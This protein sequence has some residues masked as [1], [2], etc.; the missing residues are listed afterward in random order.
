MGAVAV[1][2]FGFGATPPPPEPWGSAEYAAHLVGLF[3]EPGVLAD[4]V[5]LVGHSFGGRVAIPLYGLV[6]DR[7][8]RLVLTGVPLLDRSAGAP[9]RP[10]PSGWPGGFTGW[11]WWGRDAWSRCARPVRL[12]RLPGGPGGHP[13]RLRAVLGERV[14][15]GHGRRD[16]PVDLV[17]GEDDTEVPVEV[18]ERARPL[19]G[20]TAPTTLTTLPGVGHLTPTEAPR[21]LRPV[22]VGGPALTGV[23]RL[24]STWPRGTG[25]VAWITVP[26]ARLACVPSGL[27]WLRVAQ[28]EHYLAGSAITLRA[29]WWRS[30]PANLALAAVAAVPPA[31]PR[32]GGPWPV[33][34]VAV[35]GGR[36]AARP[37]ASRAYVR[38]GLDPPAEYPGRGLGR[39]ESGRVGVGLVTGWAAPLAVLAAL[40]VPVVV[41]AACLATTPV[42]RRLSR[43]LRRRGR[44]PP[45][46]GSTPTVVAIT[47]SYGKTSTKGHIA[48]LV[49]PDRTLVATP[50][51]FNNRA[52]LARA[53]NE[54]LADG[55]RG[56]RGRDGHLRPRRDRRPV[57]MVPARRLGDH[58]H[59]P[60]APGALRIR[61]ADR[62][63]Q[64]GDPRPRRHRGPPG[65]R[66]ASGGP[67]RGGGGP[68]AAGLRCSAADRSADVCVAA[69]PGR[70]ARC[71]CSSPGAVVAGS[72]V[73]P[74]GSSR[75]IWPAP[76]PWPWSSASSRR[77]SAPGWPT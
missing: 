20:S 41:D 46:S 36:R 31:S 19:F 57:P 2:L 77:P 50:A 1:D 17:W 34:G 49:R 39:P 59:R 37:G 73:C 76:S 10:P 75:P 33:R 71:R 47:G 11:G 53:V 16:C 68:G 63:G 9:V 6:P 69:Q 24:R 3:D 5:V 48:H 67:G 14:H 45:G 13:W 64:V 30:T 12:P 26:P 43:R 38:T 65:R 60:G 70:H 62:R 7:I 74:P 55:T 4:R 8:E 23:R 44:G 22:I 56:V 51:S 25:G 40:A 15:R 66:S 61:G 32:C 28:R 18:A 52:G 58:R 29:R 27:R 35:R 72:L 42:E 54:H 21:P